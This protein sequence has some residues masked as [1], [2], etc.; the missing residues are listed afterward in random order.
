VLSTIKEYSLRKSQVRISTI[1]TKYVCLKISDHYCQDLQAEHMNMRIID[2]IDN[3][4]IM[5]GGPAHRLIIVLRPLGT[6]QG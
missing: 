6:D 3:Y 2:C 5:E 4:D 1:Y